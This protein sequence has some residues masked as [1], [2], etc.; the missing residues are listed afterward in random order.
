MGKIKPYSRHSSKRLKT[1]SQAS[2]LLYFY[3]SQT[4][5]T[6][7]LDPREHYL[8]TGWEVAR[9]GQQ[10]RQTVRNISRNLS[11]KVLEQLVLKDTGSENNF[12]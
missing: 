1:R 3:S 11:H 2:F 7:A 4:A 10:D 6:T 5:V 12:P 9:S 8:I